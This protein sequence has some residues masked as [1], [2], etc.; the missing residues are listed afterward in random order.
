MPN[1]NEQRE[2]G[3]GTRSRRYGRRAVLVFLNVALAAGALWLGMSIPTYFRSV[4]P[5]VL[6]AAAEGTTTL[7]AAAAAEIERGRPG[8]AEPLLKAARQV[9]PEA[10]TEDLDSR[11]AELIADN[12]SYRWSGGPAPFYEQFVRQAGFLDEEEAAVIPSL[13]PSQHRAALLGFLR[14]SPNQIVQELLQ[15][16]ETGGWQR[17]FPVY[18]TSGHP[19]EATILAT[20]LLEQASAFSNQ[21]QAALREATRGALEGNPTLQERLEGIYISILTLGRYANWLELKALVGEFE[22]VDQLLFTAR[23]VQTEPSRLP[24]IFAAFQ[25]SGE[26]EELVVYLARFE[27]RGWQTLELALGMGQG[28]VATVLEF[29]KPAYRPPGFWRMLPEEIRGSQESFKEFAEALPGAAMGI[30]AGAFALCGFFLVGVLRA[31]IL[32]GQPRA[33][34]ERRLLLNLDS[35]VGGVLVMLFVWVIIEPGLLEYRPNE[36]GTLQ[37]NLA[38]I[39]PEAPA[40][41]ESA[42]AFMID[43]VTILVLLLFFVLQL[44]VFIF[45]LLKIGEIRKQAVSPEVKLH[46]MENEEN[47]FDLG[48]YVG[49][50][51]TVASLILVVLNIVDASLMAAYASTLF[52]ILFVAIL[53]VGFV[54]RYRRK[55][56]LEKN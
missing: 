41:T 27:D 24:L 4:S 43:Q 18:S 28:A 32:G 45:G 23:A 54:R 49:L 9:R 2:S 5:L 14:E 17:F 13:L 50:G 44:L 39:L 6:E 46:L 7:E 3:T 1:R 33:D 48:L 25:F 15:T 16:R 21:T 38:Q 10:E 29:E 56:I 53:K 40:N 51:G 34:Q 31:L 37:L 19:L 55:L 11:V 35:M 42:T 20:A 36:Q 22:T 8:L 12:P 47:L 30:R 52:G 26:P